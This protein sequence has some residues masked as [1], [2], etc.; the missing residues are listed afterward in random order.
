[1]KLQVVDH[2]LIKHGKQVQKFWMHDGYAVATEHLEQVRGVKLYTSY[3]G[4]LYAPRNVFYQ[5]GKE[6][7]FKGEEQLVLPVKYWEKL[8]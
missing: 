1:M 2:T 3:D 5:H 8:T 7:N 4:V 6:H